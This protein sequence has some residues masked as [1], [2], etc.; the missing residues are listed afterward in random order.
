MAKGKGDG[1]GEGA[2]CKLMAVANQA[3]LGSTINP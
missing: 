3:G 2:G 1:Y